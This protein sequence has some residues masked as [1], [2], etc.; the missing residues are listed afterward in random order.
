M[1][2]VVDKN[3]DCKLQYVM[4]EEEQ[5]HQDSLIHTEYSVKTITSSGIAVEKLANDTANWERSQ[6]STKMPQ[7]LDQFGEQIEVVILNNDDMVLGAIDAYQ[8]KGQMELPLFVGVDG[9]APAIE[10]IKN[11][12]MAGTVLNDAGAQSEAMLH[13]CYCLAVDKTLGTELEIIKNK[14]IWKPYRAI[15]AENVDEYSSLTEKSK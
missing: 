5:G 4:L 8:S 9:T 6:A 14:Y 2:E 13:L 12:V 10:A 3:G 7:W 1:K 11:K 15:T